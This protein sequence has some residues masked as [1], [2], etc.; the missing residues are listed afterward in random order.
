M[1]RAKLGAMSS[2]AAIGTAR[3][4]FAWVEQIVR[5]DRALES[6]HQVDGILAE[7]LHEVLLLCCPHAMLS[8]T[9]TRKVER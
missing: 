1:G 3:T 6:Q 4:H 9:Y 5:V 2:S 7:L 8:R